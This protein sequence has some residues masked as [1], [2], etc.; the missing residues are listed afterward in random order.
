MG[1]SWLQITV[2]HHRSI[3]A[4]VIKH[5]GGL[6]K[7]QGQVILNTRGSYAVAN[8]FV[9]TALGGV[10]LQQLAPAAAK[11]GPRSVVH[12][13]FTPRQQPNLG[14]WVQAALAVRVKGADAV[15][16]VVKQV[17]PERHQAAHGKQVDQAAAYR[18]FAGA[19]HLRHMA[20]PGKRQLGF[21]LGLVQL[22]FHLELKGV[23]GQ[24]SRWCQP[25][26][27]RGGG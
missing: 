7:E 20:V 4:Q 17:H 12:R 16:L 26:K 13:E 10:A 27:R 24:E 9:D 23:A 14:H 19:D 18:V 5:R 1:E 15:D 8:V 11:A 6:V 2:Q 3:G 22:L 21:Q 25:V